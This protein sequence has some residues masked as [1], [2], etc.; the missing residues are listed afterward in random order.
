MLLVS[1]CRPTS[2][3][4]NPHA[5]PPGTWQTAG[6]FASSRVEKRPFRLMYTAEVRVNSSFALG[7]SFFRACVTPISCGEA[8]ENFCTFEFILFCISYFYF[9]NHYNFISRR[10]IGPFKKKKK[11]KKISWL[12]PKIASSGLLIV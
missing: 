10:R 8:S 11:K 1:V 4:Y 6:D 9:S 7:R 3:R 2:C 12:W 5:K